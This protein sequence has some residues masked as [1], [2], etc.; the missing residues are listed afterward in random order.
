MARGQRPL[1]K[2]FNRPELGLPLNPA[3]DATWY[4]PRMVP[5]SRGISG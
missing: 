1:E 5:G 3:K 2:F 4:E